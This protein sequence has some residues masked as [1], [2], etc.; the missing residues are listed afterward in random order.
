MKINESLPQC[1]GQSKQHT[2]QQSSADFDHWLNSPAKQ[3]TGDE[4][5]W[6]HQTQLQHS[7]LHFD[8]KPLPAPK[9]DQEFPKENEPV[10]SMSFPTQEPQN[11]ELQNMLMTATDNTTPSYSPENKFAPL[12]T[13]LEQAIEQS[14]LPQPIHTSKLT[15]DASA[16]KETTSCSNRM[17]TTLEF[18][19]NHLFIQGEQ[20][21]LTLNL[22]ALDKQEQNELVQLIQNYLKKKGLVLS[23]LIINGVNND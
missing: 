8:A 7:E 6:Q 19:N 4:Y 14:S 15:Q 12:M 22:H 1:Y 11:F 5:Y 18:K 20:A 23:R 17:A 13:E 2:N 3:N 9:T 21:E 16:I 10:F